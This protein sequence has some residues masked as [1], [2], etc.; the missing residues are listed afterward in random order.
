MSKLVGVRWGSLESETKEFLL[1][2]SNIWDE[3]E[4]GECIYD[5]F[6]SISVAGSIKCINKDEGDYE[7]L[8]DDE[9]II[10]NSEEGVLTET[11]QITFTINEVMTVNEA[12]EQWGL[13]EGAIRNAIKSKK[14]IPGLDY[15]KAGR[16]TL[17]T[18]ESM[19]EVYGEPKSK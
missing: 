10:Y 17:I 19:F 16:I 1:Q 2:N 11:K 18:R 6:G 5:L 14:F 12:A 3:V 4:D 15:R 8:I 13:T 7:Y 9:A